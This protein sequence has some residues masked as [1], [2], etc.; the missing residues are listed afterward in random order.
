[1]PHHDEH[2]TSTKEAPNVVRSAELGEPRPS[3][4]RRDESIS[5]RSLSAPLEVQKRGSGREVAEH[6]RLRPDGNVL[7][8]NFVE[9]PGQ[10]PADPPVAH[11]ITAGIQDSPGH[12]AI[13]GVD[14]DRLPVWLAYDYA[15]AG[16]G[17]PRKLAQRLTRILEVLQDPV[18]PAAVEHIIPEREVM[19]VANSELCDQ[20]ST[21]AS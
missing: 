8:S 20:A 11:P 16:Q 2:G 15:C 1:M 12:R 13:A 17:H 3:V 4:R 7:Q 19:G 5:A 6:N 14:Q 10:L 21:H 9:E 18:G